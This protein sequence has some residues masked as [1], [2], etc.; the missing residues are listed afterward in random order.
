MKTYP[1]PPLGARVLL[2][3]GYNVYPI[4]TRPGGVGTVIAS[5]S[6]LADW[7]D[8]PL[9]EIHLDE[10]EPVLADW[11]NVLHVYSR[12]SMPRWEH[13]E[14]DP[15]DMPADTYAA[16]AAEGMQYGDRNGAYN[17]ESCKAEGLDKPSLGYI[18]YRLAECY[19]DILWDRATARQCLEITQGNKRSWE[20][21]DDADIITHAMDLL[22]IPFVAACSACADV[23]TQAQ[24]LAH[25]RKYF[26]HQF[27]P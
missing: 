3:D 9:V 19:S 22:G 11:G 6:H 20:V 10:P 7:G 17:A 21:L 1:L 14:A 24:N 8:L 18:A 16:W 2:M 25:E 4:A 13:A 26:I 15:V 5:R 12:A 23:M 27:K